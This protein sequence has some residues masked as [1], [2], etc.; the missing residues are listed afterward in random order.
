MLPTLPY[1]IGTT[2]LSAAKS[3]EISN[4]LHTPQPIQ[5]RT[6]GGWTF[7]RLKV[8][9]AFLSVSALK[10]IHFGTDT[11]FTQLKKK[12]KI[13]HSHLIYLFYLRFGTKKRH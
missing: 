2:F 12:P 9:F 8:V 13:Q 4:P 11:Y 7:R 5:I 1:S 10:S 6:A 3:F